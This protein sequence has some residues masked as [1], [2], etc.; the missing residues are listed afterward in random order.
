[1]NIELI[2]DSRNFTI[3][4]DNLTGYIWLYSHQKPIAYYYDGKVYIERNIDSKGLTHIG[5][6]KQRFKK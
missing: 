6:F 1:M 2:Y 5:I 4:K 3:I